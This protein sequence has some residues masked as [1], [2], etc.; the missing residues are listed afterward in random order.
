MFSNRVLNQ[1]GRSALLILLISVTAFSPGLFA[2]RVVPSTFSQPVAV[3]QVINAPA[4]QVWDLLSSPG[5]LAKV[6]AFAKSSSAVKWPGKGSVDRLE[7]YGGFSVERRFV[8]WLPGQGYDLTVH[9]LPAGN[10]VAQV[11]FRIRPL[12]KAKSELVITERYQYPA[13]LTTDQR[14]EVF[15]TELQPGINRYFSSLENGINYYLT[16]HQ[17]VVRNQFGEFPPYSPAVGK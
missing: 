14:T 3:A 10:E 16:T 7:Y 2:Q 13:Q 5:H 1:S 11:S 8:R 4:N 6:H 12:S 17:P 9:E 15:K